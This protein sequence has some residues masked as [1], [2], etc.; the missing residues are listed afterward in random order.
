MQFKDYYKILGVEKN[1]DSEAIKKA[2]RHLAKEWHPDKNPENPRAEEK[3]KE[4]AE[5]YDVLSDNE[6]RKKFD[7]FISFGQKKTT[8]QSSTHKQRS[9]THRKPADEAEFSDFFK[10]F[11]KERQQQ[12]GKYE[13]LKGEDLRGKI[14][15]DLEEAYL[16][17]VRILN[18]GDEKLRLTIKPG[19]EEDQILKI[20]EKGKPSKFGGKNGDLYVRIVINKH[21]VFQREG[22]DLKTEITTD[23]YS[24]VLQEKIPVKTFKGEILIQLPADMDYGKSV[25]LKGLGMPVY[26]KHNTFGDL[27]L[28]VKFNIPKKISE[29][30]K[31][32]FRELRD[33]EMRK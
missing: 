10:Q 6:K 16:G 33:I 7:D 3:F 12:K 1:S 8:T 5:A 23:F 27:Y 29:K 18:M 2:Y 24:L 25:R 28:N 30:E 4:I 22:N 14:S 13:Y 15:I 19:I 11:F 20:E 26:G 17:S 32:L 21:P 31:K 9:E